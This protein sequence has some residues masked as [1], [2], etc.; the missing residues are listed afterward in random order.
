MYEAILFSPLTPS[1]FLSILKSGDSFISLVYCMQLNR[2]QLVVLGIGLLLLVGL[3]TGLVALKQSQELRG[4]AQVYCSGAGS[5]CGPVGCC[6]GL[7]CSTLGRC[8][9]IEV[10]PT[11][12]PSCAVAGSSC[13]GISCCPGL[14]CSSLGRCIPPNPSPSPDTSTYYSCNT[15]TFVC[16]SATAESGE[17][18]NAAD[19]DR[20]CSS[21]RPSPSPE[22]TV[23]YYCNI[24]TGSCGISHYS[25]YDNISACEEDCR[26]RVVAVSPSPVVGYTYPIASPTQPQIAAG[27]PTTSSTTSNLPSS[28]YNPY[29]AVFGT[30]PN[31]YNP[32]APN[33][34]YSV[35]SSSYNNSYPSTYGYYDS[36]GN[37]VPPSSTLQTGANIGGMTTGYG[38][39]GFGATPDNPYGYL[40]PQPCTDPTLATCEFDY[41]AGMYIAAVAAP[42]AAVLGYYGAGAAASLYQTAGIAS[43]IYGG[44]ALT[45]LAG[46]AN[47][48]AQANPTNYLSQAV[49]WVQT[50]QGQYAISTGA[51]TLSTLTLTATAIGCQTNPDA[52]EC[53][54]V[55]ECLSTPLCAEAMAQSAR[56]LT[57]QVNAYTS[58]PQTVRA[59]AQTIGAQPVRTASGWDVDTVAFNEQG[60]M[61][62]GGLNIFKRNRPSSS[63][64]GYVNSMGQAVEY[65]TDEEG[66]IKIV[67]PDGSLKITALKLK[68]YPTQAALDAALEQ[69]L[70]IHPASVTS[71]RVEEEIGG[72]SV[73]V[74]GGQEVTDPGIYTLGGRDRISL[75]VQEEAILGG[76]WQGRVVSPYVKSPGQKLV[77]QVENT[78]TSQTERAL[79]Q[80]ALKDALQQDV[81]S[82]SKAIDQA[83][84]S[85]DKQEAIDALRGAYFDARMAA[86]QIKEQ[87]TML[88]S[89]YHI[90]AGQQDKIVA[91][92]NAL[93]QLSQLASDTNSTAQGVALVGKDL[94]KL[95]NAAILGQ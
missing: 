56:E 6:D 80:Q 11:P 17:F 29:N 90:T 12:T 43:Y 7:E 20:E 39:Y 51:N 72:V 38:T 13:S 65:I 83:L 88:A 26:Q 81:I 87:R 40:G 84:A 53:N 1:Q 57:Q 15:S 68:T 2:K 36:Y 24:D 76:P 21:L 79:Y 73:L 10:E 22:E 33:S 64:T 3:G 18:T 47:A 49:T 94:L 41:E 62:G 69:G 58:M 66:F 37:Y 78:A 35:Y 59:Y 8:I 9:P 48:W 28:V 82:A 70:D 54:A 42:G 19:C 44:S 67:R 77:E 23:Y 25:G 93:N 50:P 5:P 30:D 55:R 14:D 85:G 71:W 46:M 95:I 63:G 75:G 89:E 27:A 60:Y 92:E 32:Y 16:E 52:P 34:P 91:L 4:R 86:E 31:N 61:F 45:G 74:K